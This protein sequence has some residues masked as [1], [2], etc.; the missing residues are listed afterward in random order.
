MCGLAEGGGAI[1]PGGGGAVGRP[2]A[3]KDDPTDPGVSGVGDVDSPVLGLIPPVV[4]KPVRGSVAGS[5]VRG[6][7]DDSG[8]LVG[9]PVRGSIEGATADPGATGA[10]GSPVSSVVGVVIGSPVVG[11]I[12]T[13]VWGVGN[14][15]P[16]SMLVDV[17]GGVVVAP[18]AG[19]AACAPAVAGIATRAPTVRVVPSQV[20]MTHLRGREVSK[21]GAGERD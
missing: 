8:A 5:P 21:A 15:V 10:D 4:G 11:S 16:E 9:R 18:V 2:V 19:F 6:S 14:P 1:T 13:V 17:P 12:G 7:V 20:F 3:G